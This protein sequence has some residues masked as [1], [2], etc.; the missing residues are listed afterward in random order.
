MAHRI[1]CAPPPNQT[2][3]CR[4]LVTLSAPEAG[5]P[6]A[7][8]GAGGAGGAVACPRRHP[9]KYLGPPPLTPPHKGEGNRPRLWRV[10]QLTS[11]KYDRHRGRALHHLAGRRE[12]AVG[13]IDAIGGDGVAQLV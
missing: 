7:G 5:K 11:R 1:R 6:A 2:P 4:G 12:P 9:G 8:W 13:G 3:A 10:L